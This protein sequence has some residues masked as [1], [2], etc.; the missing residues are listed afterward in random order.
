MHFDILGAHL[1]NLL[2]RIA[3]VESQI[4]L[5]TKSTNTRTIALDDR[6]LCFARNK[7]LHHLGYRNKGQHVYT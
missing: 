4:L 3:F 5:F 7:L 1:F 2:S 6:L